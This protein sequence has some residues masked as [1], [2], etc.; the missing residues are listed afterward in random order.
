MAHALPVLL[1]KDAP[2]HWIIDDTGRAKQ[3]VL[4]RNDP[5]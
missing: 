3:G 2:H 4:R 1:K 5:Q